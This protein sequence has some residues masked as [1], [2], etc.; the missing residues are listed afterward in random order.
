MAVRVRRKVSWWCVGRWK[1]T[2]G[3]KGHV[4][5]EALKV[6]GGVICV[7]EVGLRV[8]AWEQVVREPQQER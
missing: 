1:V 7:W 4:T 6:V 5:G 3:F 2:T 8:A